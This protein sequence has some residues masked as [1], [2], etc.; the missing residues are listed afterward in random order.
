VF[1]ARIP[2]RRVESACMGEKQKSDDSR[3]SKTTVNHMHLDS[4]GGMILS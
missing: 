2:T 1:D 3:L 4:A